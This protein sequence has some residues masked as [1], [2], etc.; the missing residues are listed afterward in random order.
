MTAVFIV[1]LSNSSKYDYIP[2]I[3]Y[4][5]KILSKLSVL[6]IYKSYFKYEGAITSPLI[7][8]INIEIA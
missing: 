3:Y 5:V 4:T 1:F 6:M 2:D 8:H 7:F